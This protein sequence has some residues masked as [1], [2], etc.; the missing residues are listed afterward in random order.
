MTLFLLSEP[1]KTLYNSYHY[2]FK[3]AVCPC[4][5]YVNVFY[6]DK[7]TNQLVSNLPSL[8]RMPL[9]T[10][11]SAWEPSIRGCTRCW[12]R[13]RPKP[14]RC[15]TALTPHTRGKAPS[16]FCSSTSGARRRKNFWAPCKPSFKEQT[17]LTSWRY[18]SAPAQPQH[19][20]A[21]RK[22]YFQKYC[23]AQTL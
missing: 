21:S 17:A 5:M 9:L 2:Y 15:W 7:H 12:R 3:T 19:T 1:I 6:I 14:R 4:H 22:Q 8:H 16:K 13:T 23:H 11:R 20:R 10:W 18:K